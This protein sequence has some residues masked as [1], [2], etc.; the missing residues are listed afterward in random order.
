MISMSERLIETDEFPFEFLSQ[1]FASTREPGGKNP[2]D[3]FIIC[4]SVGQEIK[5]DVSRNLNR[6]HLSFQN[7]LYPR[8]LPRAASN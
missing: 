7:R 4:I 6:S 2:S 5:V 3:P 1:D 8:I